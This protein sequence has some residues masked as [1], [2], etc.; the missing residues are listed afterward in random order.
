MNT[1]KRE[2]LFQIIVCFALSNARSVMNKAETV[3]GYAVYNNIGLFFPMETL[4]TDLDSVCTEFLS[5]ST[6]EFPASI[7]STWRWYWHFF[8]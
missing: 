8:S 1:L 6:Q 3:I 5:L 2:S 4:L 7:R